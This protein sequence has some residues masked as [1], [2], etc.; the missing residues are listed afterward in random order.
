MNNTL[1]RFLSLMLALIMIA[2]MFPTSAFAYDYNPEDFDVEEA[3]DYYDE[4]GSAAEKEAFL[5][6]LSY[7]D[8]IELLHY[9]D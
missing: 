7:E 6:S 2:G 4:L 9:I 8:R 5:N 3:Y 1:N